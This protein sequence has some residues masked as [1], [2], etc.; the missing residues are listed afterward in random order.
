MSK[1]DF[2]GNELAIGDSVAVMVPDYR[3][4]VVGRIYA[5]TPQGFRVV[6]INTWNYP[7][8]NGVVKKLLQQPTQLLRI[9]FDTSHLIDLEK[10]K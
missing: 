8:K 5:E 4:F 3:S 9:D 6:Y 10:Q 7:Y 2:I 1:R